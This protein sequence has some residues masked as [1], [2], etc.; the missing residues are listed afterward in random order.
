MPQKKCLCCTENLPFRKYSKE[1]KKER[2]TNYVLYWEFDCDDSI[3]H[4]M[5]IVGI[6]LTRNMVEKV[7]M[8]NDIR[9]LK[10]EYPKELYNYKTIKVEKD[11]PIGLTA[12]KS[13]FI[14]HTIVYAQCS[15]Q[16]YMYFAFMQYHNNFEYLDPYT[17]YTYYQTPSYVYFDLEPETDLTDQMEKLSLRE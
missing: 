6:L 2:N 14:S 15:V 11:I 16:E 10:I 12:L 9:E 5:R 4:V 3:D 17:D 13:I 1:V 8:T 7:Y